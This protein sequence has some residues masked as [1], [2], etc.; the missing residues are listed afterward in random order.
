MKRALI[1]LLL[2]AVAAGGLFAQVTFSGHVQS[3]IG[4]ALPNEGDTTLHWFSRDAGQRYRFDLSASY[5]NPDGTA[6][7]SGG[8]RNNGADPW[9]LNGASV[10]VEPIDNVFRL[11]AGTGGPGGFASLGSWNE[12]N[13]AADSGG[14]NI[15]LTPA[16]DGMTFALGAS[17][18]PNN[19]TF[20]KSGYR[21]GASFGLPGTLNV[22][23]NLNSQY[24]ADNDARTNTVYAG[25]NVPALYAASGQTGL[26]RVAVDL[27]VPNLSDLG[28]VGI[29]PVVGFNVVNVTE[30]GALSTTLQSRIFMPLKDEFEMDYWVGLGLGLPLT[31]TVRADLNAGYEGKGTIPGAAGAISTADGGGTGR[32]ITGGTDPAF[33]VRPSVTFNIGGGT[34]ETGWSM[35]ALLASETVIYNSLYAYFRVGF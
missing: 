14:L 13:G 7:A 21:F 18:N 2:L 31:S 22:A 29:G 27:Y 33:I 24:N 32:S 25:I 5:T 11:Q 9:N 16:L 1:V 30:A 12:N 6:G 26:S 17:I 8:L 19:V 35:Q 20:D 34:L 15:R 10:W 4:I 23:G 28:W 3:G